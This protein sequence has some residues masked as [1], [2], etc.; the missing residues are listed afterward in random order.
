VRYSSAALV[1]LE[2]VLA[3]LAP[4]GVT[5]T[6]AL[7]SPGVSDTPSPVPDTPDADANAPAGAAGGAARLPLEETLAALLAL[8][9]AEKGEGRARTSHAVGALRCLAR[10]VRA[11]PPAPA[12]AGADA[13]AGAGA[14][15]GGGDGGG[16]QTGQ[17]WSNKEW[18]NKADELWRAL[19]AALWALVADADPAVRGE[20]A[21]A[22]AAAAAARA[23]RRDGAA[24]GGGGGGGVRAL[25]RR[26]AEVGPGPHARACPE[27]SNRGPTSLRGQKSARV[28]KLPEWSGCQSG[29]AAGRGHVAACA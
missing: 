29:R 24:G 22:L 1:A 15:G 13:G 18:S 9:T 25:A 7:A 28:V 2:N 23:E 16:G 5:D 3:A 14:P 11:C 17:E 19:T 27:R 8:S 4:P 20:A 12:D 6:P 10:L 26:A 21:A